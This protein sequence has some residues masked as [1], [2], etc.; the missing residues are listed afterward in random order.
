MVGKLGVQGACD[1]D[2]PLQAQWTDHVK[3][4]VG[5]GQAEDTLKDQGA[6][7][8]I[9]EPIKDG[10]LRVGIELI[11][12]DPAVITTHMTGETPCDL[13]LADSSA[14]QQ[15]RPDKWAHP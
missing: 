6:Q 3:V 14:K 15:E 5:P 11:K 7:L 2:D 9:H 1:R 8:L 4:V 13:V 10:L 12:A